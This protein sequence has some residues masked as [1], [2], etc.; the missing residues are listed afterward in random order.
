[1]GPRLEE[2]PAAV[3]AQGL[4]EALDR[5]QGAYPPH[6]DPPP[7]GGRGLSSSPPPLWGRVGWGAVGVVPDPGLMRRWTL[8]CWAAG[9]IGLGLVQAS[10]I[11]KFR[12]RLR[13]AVPA[14]AW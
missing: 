6:P 5:S 4:A 9:A 13:D 12:N 14:P 1:A 2:G 11:V 7:Q 8:W 3:R 10:R